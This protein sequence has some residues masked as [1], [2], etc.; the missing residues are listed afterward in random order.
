MRQSLLLTTFDLLLCLP[1]AAGSLGVLQSGLPQS[2][3]VVEQP[4]KNNRANRSKEDK[5]RS[6]VA[7]LQAAEAN[8][9]REMDH[10]LF[11]ISVGHG[12]ATGDGA[13]KGLRP[14]G[15]SLDEIEAAEVE[16]QALLA[17]LHPPSK[18]RTSGTIGGEFVEF[19]G[20]HDAV[21][22]DTS[23]R[24]VAVLFSMEGDTG[25]PT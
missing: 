9:Q 15:K 11:A 6:K 5:R 14:P 12:N 8:V 10:R 18:K 24:N 3:S 7:K 2:S 21:H 20:N 4:P 1:P 23:A 19:G 17:K 25:A 16:K 22:N 13:L